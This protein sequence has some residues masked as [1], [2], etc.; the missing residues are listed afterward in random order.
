MDY[1][2]ENKT[3]NIRFL[4]LREDAKLPEYK[5]FG[6][7]GFDLYAAIDKPIVMD[8]GEIR[9]IPLGFATEIPEGWQVAIRSRSGMASK[10]VFVVNSPGTIDS[11]YR[12]EWKVMLTFVA[13]HYDTGSFTFTISPGDRIAQGVLEPVYYARFKEVS[14]LA[15]TT[16]GAGGFGSTG[17]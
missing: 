5:T 17:K 11:D 9:I 8:P 13:P 14:E 6:S 3:W 16:R 15:E 1:G 10:G 4:R 7:A 12:G 2:R